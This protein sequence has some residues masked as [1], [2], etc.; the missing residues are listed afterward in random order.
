MFILA[1]HLLVAQKLSLAMEEYCTVL[2]RMRKI[3][4]Q[5]AHWA[6]WIKF[7]RNIKKCNICQKCLCGQD[8]LWGMD[9]QPNKWL[10][11]GMVGMGG[12]VVRI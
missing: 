6:N 8:H 11:P 7:P 10:V 3:I 5:I 1:S 4:A 12:V 9:F 2:V